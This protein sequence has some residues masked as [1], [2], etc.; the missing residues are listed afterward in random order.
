MRLALPMAATL[1]MAASSLQPA[2]AQKQ[3]AP[4]S[5]FEKSEPAPAAQRNAPPEKIA[6]PGPVAPD[7]ATSGRSTVEPSGSEPTVP[8]SPPA[9][10]N[11]NDKNPVERKEPDGL[12]SLPR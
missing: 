3:E 11:P 8:A 4:P 10:E 1:A 5:R 6:P 12:P 9:A 2:T 7:R